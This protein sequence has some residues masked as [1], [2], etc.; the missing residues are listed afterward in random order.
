[1]SWP[2]RLHTKTCHWKCTNFILINFDLIVV[3]LAICSCFRIR[4]VDDDQPVLIQR[5]EIPSR[6]DLGSYFITAPNT[7]RF[8]SNLTVSVNI[9]H[10]RTPVTVGL[11]LYSSRLP[12]IASELKTFRP[13]IIINNALF[14]LCLPTIIHVLIFAFTSHRPTWKCYLAGNYCTSKP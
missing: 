12:N 1:M 4:P 6:H 14:I 13:G 8:G 11:T 9:Y 7:F 2:Q 3:T 10:A 5:P